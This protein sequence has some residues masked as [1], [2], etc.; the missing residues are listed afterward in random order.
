MS[1]N[2]PNNAVT[3]NGVYPIGDT[4]T[5]ALPVQSI[6]SA[7]PTYRDYLGFL[8]EEQSE[9]AARLRRD[10][11]VI[12]IAVNDSDPEQASCYFPVS[13]AKQLRSE[14]QARGMEVSP[15]RTDEHNGKLLRVFFAKEP[16]GVCF[17]FG[18]EVSSSEQ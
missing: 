13:N 16:Y 6:Q 4:D 2:H 10:N 8:V 11:A 1:T 12:G 14:L 9:T 7:L 18:T 5:N 17:C 3:F 15:L